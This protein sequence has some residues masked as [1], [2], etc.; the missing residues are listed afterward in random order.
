MDQR[1]HK[2]AVD[3]AEWDVT[4]GWSTGAFMTLLRGIALVGFVLAADS[5]SWLLGAQ[6]GVEMALAAA[7]TYGVY[8]R[9]P[10]AAMALAVLYGVGNFYSWYLRAR[11]LPPLAHNGV[12]IWYGLY[13]GIRGTRVCARAM[14]P[15]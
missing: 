15:G 2:I 3:A 1:A 11:P 5:T 7:L 9:R 14:T 8:R 13:R 10:A 4:I 12:W 6:L